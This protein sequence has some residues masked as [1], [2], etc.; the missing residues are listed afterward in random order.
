MCVRAC[1]RV[2]ACVGVCVRVR[3]RAQAAAAAKVHGRSKNHVFTCGKPPSN[4]RPR[5]MALML[6][7]RH[8]CGAAVFSPGPAVTHP[9]LCPP[10]QLQLEN[11]KTRRVLAAAFGDQLAEAYMR[12]LM[13][14]VEPLPA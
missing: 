8:S 10:S 11:D 9:G 1:V 3:A 6:R 4:S 12:K 5:R 2:W 13:F 7:R 14:D